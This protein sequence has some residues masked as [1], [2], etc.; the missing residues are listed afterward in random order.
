MEKL[1][2]YTG[3]ILRVDLTRKTVS[4]ET[5]KPE[6]VSKYVGGTGL[7]AKFLYEEVPPKVQWNDPENRLILASGPLAAGCHSPPKLGIPSHRALS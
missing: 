3:R 6:T 7:G 5:V 2:G 4:D 1:G